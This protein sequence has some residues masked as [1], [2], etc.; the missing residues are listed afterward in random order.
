[1]NNSVTTSKV[2]SLDFAHTGWKYY[3]IIKKKAM[4]QKFSLSGLV[5]SLSIAFFVVVSTAYSLSL[6]YKSLVPAV[7]ASEN[8]F[9]RLEAKNFLQKSVLV[10]RTVGFSI[11]V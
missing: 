6:L 2:G 9:Y 10:E 4:E 11:K 1:M 8:M 5:V 7:N 3:N